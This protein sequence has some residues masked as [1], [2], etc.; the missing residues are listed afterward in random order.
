[1]FTES[2]SRDQLIQKAYS[3]IPWENQTTGK[4]NL[5]GIFHHYFHL[6]DETGIWTDLPGGLLLRKKHSQ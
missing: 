5:E 2:W 1:M 3:F 4:S 6:I